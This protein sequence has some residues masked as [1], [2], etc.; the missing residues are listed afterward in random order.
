M[1]LLTW[2]GASVSMMPP[3][4]AGSGLLHALVLLDV[5]DALDEHPVT[6]R[7]DLDHAAGLATVLAGDHLDLVV[8]ADAA[9]GY[10]TSGASETIFMNLRSRSSRATGPKMRVPRGELSGRMMTHAFSS[11]RM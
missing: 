2:T 7:E 5:V 10:S 4:G 3:C 9:H 1:T 6:V 11:N 8:L